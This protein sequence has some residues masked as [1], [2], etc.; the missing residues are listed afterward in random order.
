MSVQ[1]Y[2]SSR[3][4]AGVDPSG[5]DVIACADPPPDE[6]HN[7]HE[8]NPP[9]LPPRS[10]AGPP[11]PTPRRT[12][13]VGQRQN[14]M[15]APSPVMAFLVG[16]PPPPPPTPP[17]QKYRGETPPMRRQHLPLS[18]TGD[19]SYT[20][21]FSP[22][23]SSIQHKRQRQRQLEPT[24]SKM[25][26]SV[27]LKAIY[28]S[29]DLYEE[30]QL[31]VIREITA[32]QTSDFE[33]QHDPVAS[34][35]YAVE[36]YRGPSDPMVHMASPRSAATEPR[37]NKRVP[38]RKGS[39][40]SGQEP[41]DYYQSNDES[42]RM[43]SSPK[44]V[45]TLDSN[46]QK[47]TRGRMSTGTTGSSS[48]SKRPKTPEKLLRGKSLE[49]S[50]RV[51]TPDREKIGFFRK[52]FRGGKKKIN[53]G[54]TVEA[55]E[56]NGEM[57]PKVAS[58]PTRAT[59]A[60]G[61]ATTMVSPPSNVTDISDATRQVAFGHDDNGTNA[62]NSD[63]KVKVVSLA[64]DTR[65]GSRFNR[66]KVLPD[67]VASQE[68]EVGMGLDTVTSGLTNDIEPDRRDIFFAHDEVSTLTA[69]SFSRRNTDPME[70]SRTVISGQSSEPVGHYWNSA[71]QNGNSE[72]SPTVGTPTVDPFS[73]PFFQEPDGES[74]I[75]TKQ[76]AIKANFNLQV[77]VA[78]VLDPTGGTPPAKQSALHMNEP[79]PR[80]WES[81]ITELKDPLGS[82]ISETNTKRPVPGFGRP[83]TTHTAKLPPS[84]NQR[85]ISHDLR[86]E[87]SAFR[88]GS[89]YAL[90]P[91]LPA[92]DD[93]SEKDP[94]KCLSDILTKCHPDEDSHE[95]NLREKAEPVPFQPPTTS[96]RPTRESSQYSSAP[97]G[98]QEVA[99]KD[100]KAESLATLVLESSERRL[101]S[102]SPSKSSRCTDPEETTIV[103]P[104]SLDVTGFLGD[105]LYGVPT[106]D[107]K[108]HSI[109]RPVSI[110][111]ADRA[112]TS[113]S[114][115][116]GGP[117]LATNT[118]TP[119]IEMHRTQRLSGSPRRK[120]SPQERQATPP[121]SPKGEQRQPGRS[122][123]RKQQRSTFDEEEKK[124]QE[125][126]QAH[127]SSSTKAML[128]TST[129]ALSTAA[130][131][132][133]KT[134]AYLH[135]LNGEPSPRHSWRRP[136]FSS[137]SDDEYSPM[138]SNLQRKATISATASMTKKRA[139][140]LVRTDEAAFD[141]FISSGPLTPPSSTRGLTSGRTKVIS[142][143]SDPARSRVL[144]LEVGARNS[145][146]CALPVTKATKSTQAIQGKVSSKHQLAS[147][148]GACSPRSRKKA[149]ENFRRP[150]YY[151]RFN[152]DVRVAGAP[153]IFGLDL[154]RRK[155]VE[156]I[157]KGR[158]VPV[159]TMK[160]VVKKARTQPTTYHSVR[161]EDV[162][163]PIQRAGR[164]LLTKAAIPIQ[165]SA[166]RYLGYQ[167]A[168]RRMQANIV[169]QSYFRRWQCEAFLRAYKH[170]CTTIQA[171][172]RSWSVRDGIQF[173]HFHA[174]QIQK[175]VRGY[176]SATYVYDAIY[177]VSRLQA[178]LR[179]KLARLRYQRW[180][181]LRLS[182][183]LVLQAW[184]RR[185]MARQEASK[186]REAICFIQTMYRAHAVM[187]RYKDTIVKIIMIQSVTRQYFARK[188][189]QKRCL[190]KKN[191]A[192]CKIQST[193]RGFQGYTDYIFALVDILVL[194]RSM[195]KWLAKKEV[196]NIRRTLAAVKIQAQWRRQTALIGML[197]DLVHIIIVQVS[198][199]R[200]PKFLRSVTLCMFSN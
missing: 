87:P 189:T 198:M 119:V 78:Q 58:A 113:L 89:P 84:S 177:W 51:E 42:S 193:W 129:A 100:Q 80:G 25:A 37:S 68:L 176:I 49:R 138:K 195:R 126:G 151:F 10:P 103:R 53:D 164:R 33:H 59:H 172:F 152:R 187:A 13:S 168:L 93:V 34:P 181:E 55:T 7:G 161:D 102:L 174:T 183:S 88:D 67:D 169:L 127:G 69:P 104:E 21:G 109:V 28:E 98:F 27:D 156:D 162:K 46:Q 60:A 52:I 121:T 39:K 157:L 163:D 194:Q 29:P 44:K 117:T 23:S 83:E 179:G 130:C 141:S 9:I 158:V 154:Q 90:D 153:V 144:A 4:P 124:E 171:A 150:L 91:P 71:N 54:T 155:R 61:S 35:S 65:Q 165:S 128:A 133:A 125:H 192:A 123:N 6:N 200:S 17:P 120:S 15:R 38:R 148:H 95:G 82:T 56:D 63:S 96:K 131:M 24:E 114:I 185:C 190:V 70:A 118:R 76:A 107:H 116:E 105:Q 184:Y 2:H 173:K 50:R 43:T 159:R 143:S 19:A 106:S 31:R 145:L 160:T 147:K 112:N 30:E 196:Q 94:Q 41:P 45:R 191:T 1:S 79:S 108:R 170:T 5:V 16:T 180:R 134:V 47:K 3:D 115:S 72:S 18:P 14:G 32:S 74:P 111:I 139:I 85:T 122:M 135:S 142:L 199:H 40:H 186:R 92:Y 62:L 22:S 57:Y 182:T 137:D 146:A 77:H 140:S 167:E 48:N 12:H 20:S 66:L 101:H 86:R 175:V 149:R 97:V 8:K 26:N 166:R 73:S 81:P 136:D 36:S 132:N 197:Y 11:P 188:E 64:V 99:Q 178:T 75:A 110:N